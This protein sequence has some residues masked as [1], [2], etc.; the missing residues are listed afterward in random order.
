MNTNAKRF[1]ITAALVAASSA[2]AA[3]LP[4]QASS[5]GNRHGGT[6]SSSTFHRGWTPNDCIRLN[7]GDFNACNVG[8]SGR[9]DLPY[10]SVHK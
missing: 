3:V 10:Q 6:R 2:T 1:I 5:M 7:G 8:S 4:T 9:G